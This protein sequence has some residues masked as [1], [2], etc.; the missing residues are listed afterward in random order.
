MAIPDK[1]PALIQNIYNPYAG[2]LE[3]SVIC[4][5]K[6]IKIY[7]FHMLETRAVASA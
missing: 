6:N 3:E 5:C 1:V 4:L 2:G 7:D